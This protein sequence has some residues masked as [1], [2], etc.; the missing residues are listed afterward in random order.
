MKIAQD[1]SEHLAKDVGDLVHSNHEFHNQW[2]GENL[3]SFGG[4]NG[5]IPTNMWYNEYASYNFN[6]PGF[7]SSTGHFTQVVWKN[8]KE[9]GIGYSCAKSRCF[10]TGNYFPGGNFGYTNDYKNNVQDRQ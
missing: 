6:N 1:Y 7:S 10:S 8:S 5:E 9:F 2:L 4:T 3:A